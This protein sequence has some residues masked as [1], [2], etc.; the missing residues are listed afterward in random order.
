MKQPYNLIRVEA[1]FEASKHKRA[2]DFMND[3]WNAEEKEKP[4][5]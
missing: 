5:R 2:F 3:I 4:M 1:C